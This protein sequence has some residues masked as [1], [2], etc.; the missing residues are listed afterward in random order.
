MD[1][2]H[3]EML[4]NCK[5]LYVSQLSR[6][7]LSRACKMVPLGQR[8]LEENW[9]QRTREGRP[10]PSSSF[11]QDA[12]RAEP[13]QVCQEELANSLAVPSSACISLNAFAQPSR[14]TLPLP[15]SLQCWLCCSLSPML[16][17]EEVGLD[18]RNVLHVTPLGTAQI[19]VQ[20]Q[21][22][23]THGYS[24]LSWRQGSH[25]D[26]KQGIGVSLSECAPLLAWSGSRVLTHADVFLSN[27]RHRLDWVHSWSETCS[28][29]EY[30]V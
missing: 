19:Q 8:D 10:C 12:D 18:L 5:S 3:S 26:P 15:G 17:D 9:G 29:G 7:R 28:D 1:Q 2:T 22:R 25:G 30:I 20:N 13:P 6:E 16:A 11:S 24:V 14:R 4:Y 21:A 27:Q 23:V